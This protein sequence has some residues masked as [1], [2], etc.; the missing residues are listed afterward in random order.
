[1]SDTM[2]SDEDQADSD[3]TQEGAT[4][5]PGTDASSDDAPSDDAPSDDASDDGPDRPG[6]AQLEKVAGSDPP[7]PGKLDEVDEKIRHA[8]T[9]A[10]EVVGT[11][12]EPIYTDSGEEEP[13]DDQAI[14][15][16]G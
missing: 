3:E 2:P 11:E 14:T 1:M 10:E 7:D 5:G 9:T 16:P 12:E 15:P 6:D 4:S 8:R 13:S